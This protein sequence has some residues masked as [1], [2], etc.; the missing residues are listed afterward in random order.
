MCTG[1]GQSK[2]LQRDGNMRIERKQQTETIRLHRPCLYIHV[3]PS[4]PEK[5]AGRRERSDKESEKE[6]PRK[7]IAENMQNKEQAVCM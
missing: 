7:H 1:V 4:K 2:P 6:M 5:L 3:T